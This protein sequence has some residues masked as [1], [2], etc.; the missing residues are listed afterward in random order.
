MTLGVA[1]DEDPLRA[2]LAGEL[3]EAEPDRDTR[4]AGRNR[5][6]RLESAELEVPVQEPVR[7]VGGRPGS[8]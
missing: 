7:Q 5:A 8:E 3:L 1:A 4:A 6:G 2:I